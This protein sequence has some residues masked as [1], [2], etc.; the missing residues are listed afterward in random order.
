MYTGYFHVISSE[1]QNAWWLMQL[2]ALKDIVDPN[3]EEKENEST[4]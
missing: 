1:S 2:S 3:M 4:M